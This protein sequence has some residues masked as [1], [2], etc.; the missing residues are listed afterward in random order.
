MTHMRLSDS[1][2]VESRFVAGFQ[3]FE[4]TQDDGEGETHSV[5]LVS[6]EADGLAQFIQQ[7]L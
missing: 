1:I 2:E 6:D 4:I 3:V 5:T 7:E